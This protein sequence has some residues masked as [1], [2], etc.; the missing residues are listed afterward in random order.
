MQ[1]FVGKV[2]I[3]F[4][5]LGIIGAIGWVVSFDW[6]GWG[7]IKDLAEVYEMETAVMKEQLTTTITM[8]LA[9]LI[10]CVAVGAV[11]IALERI[12]VALEYRNTEARANE[13]KLIE[14]VKEI[15]Y[16]V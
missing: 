11:M 10:G 8:A 5:V 15:K 2:G 6:S 1:T 4:I 14:H 12:I 9:T 3:G 16:E 13:R 7:D